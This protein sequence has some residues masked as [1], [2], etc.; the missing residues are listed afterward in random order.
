MPKYCQWCLF[1]GG[2]KWVTFYSVSNQGD[3]TLDLN[4]NR[5]CVN[6]YEIVTGIGKL[7]S[8]PGLFMYPSR[9]QVLNVV[10]F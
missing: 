4:V 10:E 3:K 7:S 8:K 9:H 6:P 1:I 2:R 5:S